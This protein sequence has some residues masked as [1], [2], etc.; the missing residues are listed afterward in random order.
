M[1]AI[2]YDE[3]GGPDVLQFKEMV[4]PVPK[5]NEV[6]V[7]VQ[8]TTV[9]Y[10]D[11]TARNFRHMPLSK[12]NMPLVLYYPSRLAFGFFKPRV[13]ILGSEFSGVVESIGKGVKRFHPGGPVYG[14]RGMSMG[15][16]AEYVCMPEE[17]TLANKPDNLSHEEAAVFP[18]GAI[19]ALN[20]L[21]KASLQKG[22]TVLIN[23]ASGGIGSQAVQ[24]AKYFG[25]KVTGVCSTRRVEFV[26]ALGADSVIDY[27]HTDFTDGKERYDLIFDILGRSSFA[28]CKR[29]LKP[30]GRYLLASFKIKQ[31][32]Q[33]MWT[34]ATGDK[35]VICTLS[36]DKAEDLEFIT[37][38]IEAGHLKAVIDRTFPLEQAADAHR[39]VE[40]GH[41]KGQVV[42]TLTNN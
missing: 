31:L 34:K 36:G 30:K 18:Y 14:Y 12:F 7:Q 27:T 25:A 10:G 6:C 29:V 16:Y 28:R 4:K 17:G 24:L 11:L 32:M 37:G 15:A 13:H 39:Y 9:N 1:K 19:V 42:I 23:G 20:L 40:D 33:M 35:K 21:K 22:E 41:K 5:A 3:Y 26:K 38:I 8:A 2:V